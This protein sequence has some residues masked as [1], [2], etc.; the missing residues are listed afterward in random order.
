[1]I[2]LLV[3]GVFFQ[4][5]STGIARVWRSLLELLAVDDN[6]DVFFLD[7]GNAP[8]VRGVEYIPFPR[9]SEF[10]TATDSF[11]IQDV[12]DEFHIDVFTSSYYT[13][14]VRTPMFLMVY[15]MIP[16]LF[17]FDMSHREWMEKIISISYAQRYI[18]ISENTRTD[19]L[20]IYPEIPSESATVAHC[21]VDTAVFKLRSPAEID[22]FRNRFGLVRPYFLF[23][24]SRIQH[25]GYKN[26]D[27]FFNA[28]EG[29]HEGNF[30]IFCVG[31]EPVIEDHVL[32]KLP[33]GVQCQRVE[34]S[35][36]EL[37]MAYSGAIALVYPSLYEGFGMPVI[38]AMASGCPVITTTHGSL[39]EAA[40]DAACLIG[41]DSIAE[42]REAIH[43]VQDEHVG[44]ALRQKGL[45]HAENFRWSAMK[46]VLVDEMTQ[47]LAESRA[48]KY[49]AF[50]N[51]WARLRQI[52]ANVDFEHCR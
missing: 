1:M 16:E 33:P 34:L 52:Q 50:I 46:S 40:G 43:S 48:G 45:R 29:I 18:C 14:P 22:S 27:L 39:A 47:L 28:I 25:N 2:N 12:C 24:G 23:V 8:Q 26:S 49:R 7:R 41:G 21:G 3:D 31:G 36:E 5:N 17:C 35:D 11:L 13:T 30:D 44:A 42:M 9:Y 6:I 38:E 51:E 37:S 10:N 19:L 4:L 15:D 32:K 20:T